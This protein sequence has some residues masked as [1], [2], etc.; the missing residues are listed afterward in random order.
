MR[1]DGTNRSLMKSSEG[2]C[3]WD[4]LIPNNTAG[5]EA[6]LLKGADSKLKQNHH[7]VPAAVKAISTLWYITSSV[8]SQLS[9]AMTAVY[10]VLTRPHLD[11][12]I[13]LLGL[14]IQER[15]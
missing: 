1:G 7:C 10:S 2:K 15:W 3:I 5:W 9:V 4:E 8:A 13:Q 11:N 12:C 6:A 14:P